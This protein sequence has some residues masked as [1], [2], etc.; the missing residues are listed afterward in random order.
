M[1]YPAVKKSSSF[2]MTT[3]LSPIGA[4][5]GRSERLGSHAKG[6]EHSL[7]LVRVKVLGDTGVG[8]DGRQREFRDLISI[9]LTDKLLWDSGEI[10]REP[11]LFH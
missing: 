7:A 8:T 4:A 2:A 6:V 3:T 11:V 9:S 10:N 5:I 1:Q